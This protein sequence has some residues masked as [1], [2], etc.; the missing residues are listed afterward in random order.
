MIEPRID[1]GN[2]C[3]AVAPII[4]PRHAARQR[5][6]LLRGGARRA[7]LRFGRELGGI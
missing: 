6:Q 2:T 1:A 3:G 4:S 7:D 5:L